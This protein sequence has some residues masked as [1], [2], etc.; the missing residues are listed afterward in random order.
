LQG[1]FIMDATARTA[2][3]ENPSISVENQ[4]DA[5]QANIATRSILFAKNDIGTYGN[6]TRSD[7]GGLRVS[8]S[9]LEAELS[10]APTTGFETGGTSI[11]TSAVQIATSLSADTKTVSIKADVNNTKVIHIGNSSGVTTATGYPLSPG[12]SV[13]LDLDETVDIW[14]ISSAGGQTVYWLA[15]NG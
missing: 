11:T 1:S 4:I 12:D 15:V 10:I 6:I 9:E 13:D 2:Q 14:A 3:T 7:G 8:V 5:T